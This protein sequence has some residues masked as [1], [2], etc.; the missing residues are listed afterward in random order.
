[1]NDVGHDDDDD[2][3]SSLVVVVM[4]TKMKQNVLI[5]VCLKPNTPKGTRIRK[6]NLVIKMVLAMYQFKGLVQCSQ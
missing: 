3:G 5:V 1:M 6:N 4:L 2:G